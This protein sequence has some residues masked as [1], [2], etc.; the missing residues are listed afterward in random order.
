MSDNHR[1]CVP[2]EDHRPRIERDSESGPDPT[3]I[4]CPA[5]VVRDRWVLDF[6]LALD[7]TYRWT[8][9]VDRLPELDEYTPGPDLAA[10]IATLTEDIP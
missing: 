4:G 6:T 1:L 9:G 2:S 3:I 7:G 8:G 10:L 5:L